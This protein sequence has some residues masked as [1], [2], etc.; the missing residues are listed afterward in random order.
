MNVGWPFNLNICKKKKKKKKLGFGFRF[1]LHSFQTV[2][3]FLIKEA[4]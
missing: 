3:Y 1:L 4:Y 2:H